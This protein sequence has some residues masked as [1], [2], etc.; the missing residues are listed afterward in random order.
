MTRVGVLGAGYFAQFQIAAWAAMEDVTLIAVADRSPEAQDRVRAAHPNIDVVA[1]IDDLLGRELDI[2]DIATPPAT[3]AD[4]ID[5]ALGH[6]PAL[7]CQ[8]PFCC[9]LD[10]ARAVLG[11]AGDTPLIIHENFRFQ[12]WHREIARL[13]ADGA[14]GTPSQA[15][16][17]LRPGDGVGPDA[18][19]DRQPYFQQMPRFLIR[20]TAI[21]FIDTYRYLFGE[22]TAVYADLRRCN[23]V[24]A[25]ED[26]G[27]VL[28]DFADGLRASFDGNRTLDHAADNTRLTMGEMEVEGSDGTIRLDG[29]GRIALRRRGTPA[30]TD[31]P[32]D[33][34]TNSFAGG[35]VAAFQRHVIDGL[36]GRAPIETR[37]RD[38]LTNLEIEDAI[39]RSSDAGRKLTLTA[40]A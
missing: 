30:W 22:V 6:V 29:F 39:Y 2:L 34:D 25:G 37:A 33:F 13:I 7:I 32:L 4:M 26:A 18:Y 21:H 17:T 35:C 19:L 36:A 5:R 20:E 23:P 8:K 24:I 15:R 3:H 10:E 9:N 11:R 16:F 31:H 38:Y 40:P 12:P 14:I 27:F 28:F 1:E